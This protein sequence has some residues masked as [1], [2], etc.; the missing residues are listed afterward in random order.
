MPHRQVLT[1]S[2][3]KASATAE[4]I[5]LPIHAH[6]PFKRLRQPP[7]TGTNYKAK[8]KAGSQQRGGESASSF[9]HRQLPQVPP[10]APEPTETAARGRVPTLHRQLRPSH[11]GPARP[12]TGD[13]RRGTRSESRRGAREGSPTKAGL[14][15]GPLPVPLRPLA[16][17]APPRSRR[18]IPAPPPPQGRLPGPVEAHPPHSSRAEAALTGAA[19]NR[20]PPRLSGRLRRDRGSERP[21]RACAKGAAGRRAHALPAPPGRC[22]HVRGVCGVEAERAAPWRAGVRGDGGF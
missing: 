12:R 13:P 11:T 9:G 17:K 5:N 1:H 14:G 19:L 18:R 6:K 4:S 8:P 22:G 20:R 10:R 3:E 2:A 21:H 15:A 16:G 7:R